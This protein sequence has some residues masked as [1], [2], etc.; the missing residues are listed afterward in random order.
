MNGRL[1]LVEALRVQMVANGDGN[2]V[3][4]FDVAMQFGPSQVDIA[5]LQ[6]HLFVGQHRIA[7]RERQR[8]AVVQNTQLVGNHFD[9]AGRDVLVDR[10]GLA[11]L[12]VT[13]DG[14]HKLGAHRGRPVVDFGS[15][16]GSDHNLR[17]PAAVAQ[18][19]K[20]KIA[21]IAPLVHPSHEHN[22]GAGV[23]GAQL[24]AHMST[25]QVT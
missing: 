20:D 9:L 1:D 6:A 10:V 11:Q 12:G 22:F 8:L 23:G 16:I 24:A 4:Q 2:L 7:G 5:I 3:A 14:N 19:E 25:F 17:D 15:G 21:E 18:V 13:D